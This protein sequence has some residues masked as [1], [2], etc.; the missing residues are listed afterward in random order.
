MAVKTITQD[1]YSRL[2]SLKGPSESF[3]D[4]IRR[5]TGKHSLMELAGMLSKKE[6]DGMRSAIR[7]MRKDADARMERTARELR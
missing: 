7:D 3:S 4:V 2:A 5:V 1:A 6:A